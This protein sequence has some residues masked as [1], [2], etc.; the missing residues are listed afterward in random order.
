MNQLRGAGLPAAEEIFHRLR[1]A[2]KN[3]RGVRV[4]N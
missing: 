4:E 1:D 2:K 3:S